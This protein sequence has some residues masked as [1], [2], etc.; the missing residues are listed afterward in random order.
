M[1]PH[2][3]R[4]LSIPSFGMRAPS[5]ARCWQERGAF[6]HKAPAAVKTDSYQTMSR[7]HPLRYAIEASKSHKDKI[8]T[9]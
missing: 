5:S 9:T 6:Q 4:A 2:V 3:K 1:H 7:V 8:T